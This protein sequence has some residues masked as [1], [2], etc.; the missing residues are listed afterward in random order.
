MS[1]GLQPTNGKATNS[2]PL[3]FR[4]SSLGMSSSYMLSLSSRWTRKSFTLT[5]LLVVMAIIIILSG[6]ILSTADYARKKGL[7][8]RAEAEIA[9]ISAAL[10]SY[11]A[12]NGMYPR[13]PAANTTIGTTTIPANVTDALNAR[14]SG[15][16]TNSTD[17]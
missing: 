14:T 3:N 16:P 13:G 12:D 5:E 8:A 9:G 6:L 1:N 7:R 17:P 10:E 11:K 4:Q 15:D 2:R